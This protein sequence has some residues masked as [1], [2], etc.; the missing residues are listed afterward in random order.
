MLLSVTNLKAYKYIHGKQLLD[1]EA[2]RAATPDVQVFE[3]R[4]CTG[5]QFIGS[6]EQKELIKSNIAF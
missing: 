3:G 6:K 2:V 5:D 1:I 4:V